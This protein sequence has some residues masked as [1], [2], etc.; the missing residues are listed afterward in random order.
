[1]GRVYIYLSNGQLVETT[2]DAIKQAKVPKTDKL[3]KPYTG[4]NKHVQNGNRTIR[5]KR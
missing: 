2:E 5:I 3:Y 4:G 1:M